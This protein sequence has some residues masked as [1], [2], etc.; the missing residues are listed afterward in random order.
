MWQYLCCKETS[1]KNLSN[2]SIF[3][4]I[5]GLAQCKNP[6]FW[7]EQFVSSI[8]NGS[9]GLYDSLKCFFFTL[10]FIQFLV[11][12][13]VSDAGSAS[14]CRQ[15]KIFSVIENQTSVNMLRYASKN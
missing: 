11:R 6:S 13:V 10:S 3:C 12:Y 9:D 4:A 2:H 15:G 5:M 1:Y 7:C 8:L 14:V